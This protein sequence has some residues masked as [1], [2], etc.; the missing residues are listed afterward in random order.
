MIIVI[1]EFDVASDDSIGHV[2]FF[3]CELFEKH[4]DVKN[5]LT[6]SEKKLGVRII[7]QQHSAPEPTLRGKKGYSALA[8]DLRVRKYLKP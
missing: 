2:H 3:K 7:S 8:F 5:A 1:F 4:T 6:D